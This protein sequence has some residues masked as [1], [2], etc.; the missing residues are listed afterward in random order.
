M[1]T[2]QQCFDTFKASPD[3]QLD[4]VKKKI[5]EMAKQLGSSSSAKK[6]GSVKQTHDSIPEISSVF[7]HN[8]GNCE[9]P[10]Q[11]TD[12][13]DSR[14]MAFGRPN[15]PLQ[16]KRQFHQQ[17]TRT[18]IFQWAIGTLHISVSASATRQNISPDYRTSEVISPQ[19]SYR[20]SIEFVP[21]LAL[22]RLRGLNLS[23]DNTQDQRG[24]YLICPLISTF[25][26]IPLESEIFIFVGENN[27][28]GVQ[29]LFQ[30]GLAAPSDRDP[31]GRTLLMV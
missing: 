19:K 11:P 12:A 28:E 16:L 25:A 17:W 20:I 8:R 24:F 30:R 26:V 2:V 10:L 15:D 9:D 1:P 3:H 5:D 4:E 14:M 21:A 23:V 22:I 18:W 29:N 27:V 31:S 7:Y 6:Q 13:S